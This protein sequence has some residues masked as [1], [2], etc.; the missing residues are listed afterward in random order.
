MG[1]G[2][3]WPVMSRYAR[4]EP[5]AR[6]VAQSRDTVKLSV[7]R[8]KS[9]YWCLKNSRLLKR[10][11]PCR[12]C[13]CSKESEGSSR[14]LKASKRGSTTKEG[15]TALAA[16]SCA[17]IIDTYRAQTGQPSPIFATAGPPSGFCG[18][19]SSKMYNSAGIIVR[20][21]ACIC[22]SVPYEVI[23]KLCCQ[24]ARTGRPIPL[25]TAKIF[26][27]V[28]GK[29]EYGWRPNTNCPGGGKKCNRLGIKNTSKSDLSTK[30]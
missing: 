1:G 22:A 9:W 5:T 10:S 23:P 14:S 25:A 3:S 16:T 7:V 12:Q 26:S 30:S 20:A 8:S 6:C 24:S 29:K 4:Q 19:V 11:A 27:I 28:S 13:T 21:T 18:N 15:S 17:Y 2:C